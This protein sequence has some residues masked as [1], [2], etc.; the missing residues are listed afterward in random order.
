MF[1]SFNADT[2]KKYQEWV[3]NSFRFPAIPDRVRD[4]L[5]HLAVESPAG[6]YQTLWPHQREAVFRAI[7]A[8]EIL[9]PRDVGWKDLLLNVVR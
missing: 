1:N 9:K 5:L 6:K 8:N 2:L 3:A 7:F 4:Y